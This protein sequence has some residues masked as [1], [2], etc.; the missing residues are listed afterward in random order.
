MICFKFSFFTLGNMT[1]Q[2]PDLFD[3]YTA[4][5][6]SAD[7]HTDIG[8]PLHCDMHPDST[9]DTEQG[10]KT[11]SEHNHLAHD[12]E[13]TPEIDVALHCPSPLPPLR[14]FAFHMGSGSTKEAAE[15]LR[16][17]DDVVHVLTES[18]KIGVSTRSASLESIEAV[19]RPLAH[20]S[21]RYRIHEEG[22]QSVRERIYRKLSEL[23]GCPS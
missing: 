18:E 22:G 7:E 5:S 9:S 23:E 12:F 14:R 4:A 17:R 3:I 6:G 1:E 19:L 10:T 11:S 20:A 8:S 2:T 21:S 13:T 15:H 16:T